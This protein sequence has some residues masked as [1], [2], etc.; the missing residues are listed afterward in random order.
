MVSTFDANY[1]LVKF[2]DLRR[3]VQ[4]LV[5]PPLLCTVAPALAVEPPPPPV[6]AAM[7]TSSLAKVLNKGSPTEDE[8]AMAPYL[9]VW[10]LRSR[11]FVS[12]WN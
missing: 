4:I 3:A 10:V 9:G 8:R 5:G 2:L 7:T 1:A 6:P 11:E 12:T